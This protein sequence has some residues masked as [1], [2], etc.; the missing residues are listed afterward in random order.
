M[1][2]EGREERGALTCREGDRGDDRRAG[3]CEE[4]SE[5]TCSS[6]GELCA[7]DSVCEVN[8]TAANSTLLLFIPA[9]K[10]VRR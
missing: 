9:A 6:G 10:A 5:F 2:E 3:P 4:L 1:T 7:C 8:D